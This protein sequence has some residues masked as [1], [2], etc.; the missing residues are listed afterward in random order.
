MK[1][2][3]SWILL[4]VMTM[5]MVACARLQTPG[6]T[7]SPTEDPTGAYTQTPT[8]EPTETPTQASTEAPTETPKQTPTEAPTEAPTQAPTEAPTEAPTQAPTE[9]PTEAPTQAPTEAP[10]EAP[11]QA[12]T[13]APTEAPTQAPTEAPTEAQTEPPATYDFSGMSFGLG[14]QMPDFEVID[15]QGNTYGLYDLLQEKQA[16]MLNFWFVSCYYCQLEFPYIQDAYEVYGDKVEILAL[17]PFDAA[18]S[19][20]T[21]ATDLGLTFPMVQER[22]GLDEAFQVSGY[23][24]TVIIDRYGTVCLV[25]PGSIPYD[26]VWSAIFDYFTADDYTQKL[27]TDV[28]DLLNS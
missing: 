3:I 1:K 6:D 8:E 28:N 4:V 17:N 20:D 18:A 25:Q 26:W 14:T 9:A 5:S 15:L 7:V 23:P 16:V 19:M 21:L 12:P 27:F 2:A 24:T 22:I 11:T 10:T 13:E